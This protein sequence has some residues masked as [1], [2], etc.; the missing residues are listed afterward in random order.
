M[1]CTHNALNQRLKEVC[2][3]PK[4]TQLTSNRGGTV[5]PEPSFSL[6]SFQLGVKAI[7]MQLK[8]LQCISCNYHVTS[9]VKKPGARS[10]LVAVPANAQRLVSAK[11][12]LRKAG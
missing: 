1:L 10:R 4:F 3:F 9:P 8:I 11:C 7:G 5:V 2:N 6:P 12:L